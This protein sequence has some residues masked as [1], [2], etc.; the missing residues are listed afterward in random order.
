MGNR[1]AFTVWLG[2]TSAWRNL[3]LNQLTRQGCSQ[4]EE[5]QLDLS[6]DGDGGKEAGGI[7]GLSPSGTAE[8]RQRTLYLKVRVGEGRD[9]NKT[10]VQL[11]II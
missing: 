1:T 10:V 5:L 4:Q 8:Q 9:P 3:C 6:S 11:N 2:E 7:P